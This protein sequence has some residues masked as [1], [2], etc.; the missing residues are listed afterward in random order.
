MVV[1]VV[2]SCAWTTAGALAATVEA[3]D[4][5]YAV[6]KAVGKVSWV[7]V[8]AGV[9]ATKASILRFGSSI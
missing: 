6:C 8:P 3:A 9:R 4:V 5:G 2:G 1:V 7:D